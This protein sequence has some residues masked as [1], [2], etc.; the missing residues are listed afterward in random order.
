MNLNLEGKRALVCGA[1]RGIGKASA[2]ELAV[3][4]ASVVVLARTAEQ[5]ELVRNELPVVNS[6][7]QHV[8]V[9]VDA[10]DDVALITAVNNAVEN[11]GPINILVN[12]TAGPAAGRLVDSS[13]DSLL[14]AF[15]AHVLTAQ[16]LIKIL[17]PGM[18]QT[19]YGRVINIVSTSVKQ[20]I[21]GLG[22]SNTIR[23]AMASWSKTLATE[24]AGRHITVNNILPGA[25]ET[26]RLEA[27]ITRQ[28]AVRQASFEDVRDHMLTEIPMG[29]FAQPSEI[30]NAVVFLASPAA[31]YI[32]G[33]SILVDGGRTRAL[34]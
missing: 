23:G 31:A 6:H 18:V 1:S 12:N 25:T 30:A 28:A 3:N 10:T 2:M 13:V 20:P 32:T 34:S 19:S 21:D 33:T 7:Q 11:H 27:I 16:R 8:A 29:R 22:V 15:Q 14:Q 24:L 5:L 9:A 26:E 17:T 4:G